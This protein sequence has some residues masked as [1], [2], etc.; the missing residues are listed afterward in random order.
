MMILSRGMS[1]DVILTSIRTLFPLL[2][3]LSSQH[4][5]LYANV[6]KVKLIMPNSSLFCCWKLSYRRFKL[7]QTIVSNDP[8]SSPG[9]G[10][11]KPSLDKR[12]LNFCSGTTTY[13]FETIVTSS[14][15]LKM[16]FCNPI[17]DFLHRTS[18]SCWR[19]STFSLS[20]CSWETDRDLVPCPV[21]SVSC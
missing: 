14:L 9:P 4:V 10:C 8:Q 12:A 6:R 3:R 11:I 21:P 20:W 13:C 17:L 19:K 16:F 5:C 2:R 1:S 7:G 15:N 18:D